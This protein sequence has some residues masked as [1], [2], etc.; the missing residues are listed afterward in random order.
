MIVNKS[1]KQ[2]WKRQYFSKEGIIFKQHTAPNEILVIIY[3]E[4]NQIKRSCDTKKLKYYL[5]GLQLS[6]ILTFFDL[7]FVHLGLQG[8]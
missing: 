1:P 7:Q 8:L 2:D 5:C 3:Y 4:I 6:L